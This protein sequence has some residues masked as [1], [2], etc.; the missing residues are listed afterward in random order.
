MMEVARG[1]PI[2]CT[3]SKA[4]S[5]I[6]S[7]PRRSDRNAIS[8]MSSQQFV[9]GGIEDVLLLS[10]GRWFFQAAQMMRASLLASATAALLCP[11]VRSSSSA[12]SCI[13]WG[14]VFALALQSTERAPWT[15][16][17]LM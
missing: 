17:I 11:L 5:V 8:T 15:R 13:G 4:R 2:V 12:Q 7:S 9:V 16:S 3:A 14:S 6:G 1:A 10:Y